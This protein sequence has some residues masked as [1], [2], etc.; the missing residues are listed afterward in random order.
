[1]MGSLVCYHNCKYG[2]T[3]I[4]FIRLLQLN[5][6]VQPSHPEPALPSDLFMS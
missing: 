5:N 4:R 2:F 1:M 6:C 3:Y